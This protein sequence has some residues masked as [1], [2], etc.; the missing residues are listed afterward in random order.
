MTITH[1]YHPLYG[2]QVT[3]VRQRR[4]AQPDLIVR[5]P[6]GSHTAIAMHLTDYA[7]APAAHSSTEAPSLLDLT[8]LRQVVQLVER[9]R[10][11][12]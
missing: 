5:L 7:G 3:V 4:G 8:G 1:P 10:Q 6:D 12:H 2:Q 11:E 9:L